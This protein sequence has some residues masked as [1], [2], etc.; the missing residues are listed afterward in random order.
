MIYLGHME[1]SGRISP[2]LSY[3]RLWRILVGFRYHDDCGVRTFI[4]LF[5]LA[6]FVDIAFTFEGIFR[7]QVK[8]IYQANQGESQ[9]AFYTKVKSQNIPLQSGDLLLIFV[10]DY[11][12]TVTVLQEGILL[13]FLL[14]CG[15]WL[16][17]LSSP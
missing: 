1:Q 16:V 5:R 4:H 2:S 12:D 11:L 15:S 6:F 10:R 3:W 17:L 7:L 13:V 8:K 14:S 9:D